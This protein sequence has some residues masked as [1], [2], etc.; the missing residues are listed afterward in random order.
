M[1]ALT[2]RSM[3]LPFPSDFTRSKSTLL[4]DKNLRNAILRAISTAVDPL[5]EKYTREPHPGNMTIKVSR[6]EH[7]IASAD[8]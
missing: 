5:S 3:H 8:P 4:S 6:D 1:V 7:A 2:L